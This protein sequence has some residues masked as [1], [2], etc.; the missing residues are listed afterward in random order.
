MHPTNRP[1]RVLVITP[2]Y[3]PDYGPS[4][5]IYTAL[6]ED[7]IAMGDEVHVVTAFPNYSGAEERYKHQKKLVVSESRNGVQIYRTF[8]FQMAKKSLVR[9]LMYHASYNLFS[10]LAALKVRRPDVILADAPTLWSG[11]PL[12]IKAILPGVPFIYVV[13]DIYPDVLVKAG[14]L[15]SPRIVNMIESI[16]EYYYSRAGAISVLSTGFQ[17]NLLQK[18]VPPKKLAIIPACVDTNFFQPYAHENFFRERW[19]LKDK[20]VVLY[21]GNIGFTQG[22][23]VVLDA[24]KHL[25]ACPDI[26]FV[27]VGEGSTREELLAKAEAEKLSQ[28]Q[29]HPFQP[30]EDVPYLYSMADVC[31]VTLNKD[32]NVESVPSKTYTIMAAGRPV[33]ATANQ[34]TEVWNLLEQSQAGVC[35][36][37]GDAETLSK[38]ILDMY[39]SPG[40]RKEKGEKGR[41]FVARHYSR[42]VASQQY[43]NEILRLVEQ[44]K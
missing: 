18:K 2:Q 20:F 7:L 5:P 40:I 41:E 9:R 27:I 30:R 21:A 13:H 16:E 28:V 24:A 23:E 26:Q 6:C 35:C 36:P 38:A 4:A 33:I 31:L 15:H 1:I 32:I 43:Q 8:I 44:K 14:M 19:N 10:T 12:L 42:S 17:D 34:D 22:L 39:Q 3:A 37:P 29:F 11:L 25:E